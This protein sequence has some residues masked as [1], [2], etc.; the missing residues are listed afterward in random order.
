MFGELITLIEPDKRVGM[1]D[2]LTVTL[3]YSRLDFGVP[4]NLHIGGTMN[5]AD[6]SIAVL[7]TALRRRFMFRE[8]APDAQ[9]LKPIDGIPLG[10]VLTIINDRVE[11]LLDREHRIGHAF[12]MRCRHRDDIDA[13]MRDRVIPLLQE[14]F[15]ENWSR[16]QAVVGDGFIGKRM[17]KAPPGIDGDARESWFVRHAFTSNAYLRLLDGTTLPDVA[18]HSETPEAGTSSG[19]QDKAA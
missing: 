9:L 1:P 11:Y 7:D 2:A 17:I 19:V 13:V 12:F 8:I 3:P 15:F 10:N 14:Y 6:R 16:V 18:G 4:A 5:T